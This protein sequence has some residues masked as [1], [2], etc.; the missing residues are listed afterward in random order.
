[1]GLSGFLFPVLESQV[2]KEM[3]NEMDNPLLAIRRVPQGAQFGEPHPR[4]KYVLAMN[5][6]SRWSL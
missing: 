3:N 1:M 6:A 4:F 2:E 5:C